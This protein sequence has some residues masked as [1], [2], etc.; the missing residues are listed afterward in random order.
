V[1]RSAIRRQPVTDIRAF[2]TA[3]ASL[4][5]EQ[6]GRRPITVDVPDNSTPAEFDTAAVGGALDNLILNAIQ[7]SYDGAPIVLRSEIERSNLRLSVS[8]K[9]TAFPKVSANI[10]SNPSP[11]AV[12]TERDSGWRWFVRWLTPTA[13]VHASS[14]AT[15]AARSLW[16]FRS[17]RTH[18][19]C[20]DRRRRKEPA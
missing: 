13:A 17:D 9:A 19:R 2:L 6:A 12:R 8:D 11:P 20:T 5:R 18:D 1:Q 10:C 7:N 15:T 4:F 14:T 16:R 3:H